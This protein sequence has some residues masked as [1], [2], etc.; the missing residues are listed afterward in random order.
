MAW[1]RKC[2][3]D[4]HH[5]SVWMNCRYKQKHNSFFSLSFCVTFPFDV[6]CHKT[7]LNMHVFQ[8]YLPFFVFCFVSI[9]ICQIFIHPLCSNEL[10]KC[11]FF[12]HSDSIHFARPTSHRWYQKCLD[13]CCFLFHKQNNSID[14]KTK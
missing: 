10:R 6:H 4:C 9:V 13:H 5:F 1:K 2:H 12:F 11:Q 14:E 3:F 8:F 7:D